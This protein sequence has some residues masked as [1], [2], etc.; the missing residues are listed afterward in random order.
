MKIGPEELI[1][2]QQR[3]RTIESF[4]KWEMDGK[5]LLMLD[6]EAYDKVKNDLDGDHKDRIRRD[7]QLTVNYI[8]DSMPPHKVYH[9]INRGRI[10]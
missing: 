1:D 3:I 10:H 6:A 8:D 4:M 9:L 2:G 5:H 7:F